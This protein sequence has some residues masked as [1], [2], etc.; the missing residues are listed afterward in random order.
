MT[1]DFNFTIKDLS[2]NDLKQGDT[3]IT[4]TRVVA[5]LLVQATKGDALKHYEWAQKLIKGEPLE[6]DTSD[7]EYLKKFISDTDKI[8]I[9][10]KA[11]IQKAF[12]QG[13]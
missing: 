1:L 5:N 4:A 3:P 6:L 9:L 2:D 8:I 11:Q 7:T 12:L 13:K 10:I